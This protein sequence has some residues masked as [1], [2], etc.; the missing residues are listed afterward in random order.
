M[1]SAIQ[2]FL[3][4]N[5]RWLFVF[6]L[7]VIVVPFVFTIGNSPGLSGGRKTKN[8]KV[9]NY[10]LS[11]R[12]DL[13][14]QA[15]RSM[16]SLILQGESED[17][18]WQAATSGYLFYRLWLLSLAQNLR[19][20]E[21]NDEQLQAF[22][23]TRK[24]FL[25]EQGEFQADLYNAFLKAWSMPFLLKSLIIE[26]YQCEQMQSALSGVGSLLP[27]EAEQAY[28]T[29]KTTYNLEYWVIENKEQAPETVSDADLQAYFQ[30][31]SEDFRVPQKADVTLLVFNN[32]RYRSQLPTPSDIVLTTYLNQHS[33]AFKVNGELP[34]FLSIKNKVK[35]AWEAEQLKQLAGAAAHQLATQVYEQSLTLGSAEWKQL[36][37]SYGVQCVA[38]P[39]YAQGDSPQ[40][41]QVSKEVLS[42]AFDL[43]QEH[44]LS[45]P[46]LLNEGVGLLVLNKFIPSCIPD[47]SSVR[48]SVLTAIKKDKKQELFAQKI[49]QIKHLL[50]T[51][52]KV[53][54]MH[55]ESIALSI[56]HMN[57]Q[58]LSKVLTRDGLLE[59][60]NDLGRFKNDQWFGAYTGVGGSV[61]FFFCKNKIMPQDFAKSTEFKA[62]SSRLLAERKQIQ[63]QAVA[64]ELI[65]A[66]I[67]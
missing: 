19:L 47:L 62:F 22:I 15:V 48:S 67:N 49:A 42:H 24:R 53:N 52:A 11:N 13:Q 28:R 45:D 3:E 26:D 44:F 10:D 16:Q 14:E 36:I 55:L 65:A 8:L 17:R 41:S 5:S 27:G 61:V 57:F 34:K 32:H 6:L 20:P 23:R 30:K 33:E 46:F 60:L 51:K 35:D 63:S 54:N 66:E 7:I 56:E 25:N 50:N 12:K 59:L 43:N 18:A 64:Q 4:R 29:I 31:H 21:P 2:K 9:F 1:L 58:S 39:P 40:N 37:Q 38:V